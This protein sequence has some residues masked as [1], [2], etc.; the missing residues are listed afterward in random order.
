MTVDLSTCVPGQLCVNK[1]GEHF[2][3]VKR[4]D[5]PIHYPHLLLDQHSSQKTFTNDGIYD[6]R[7]PN[8]KYNIV[9]IIP[10]EST[11]SD[12]HPSLVWWESCP[13]ITDRTPTEADGNAVGWVMAKLKDS[14]DVATVFG[15][16][17][18]LGQPWIH[19]QDWQ[20]PVLSNKEKAL[21]LIAKRDA[22]SWKPTTDDW[23]VIRKGL[24]E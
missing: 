21:A 15:P 6:F 16:S 10:M 11:A 14:S 19:R 17:I 20:P 3:Y 18:T 1:D 12:K 9:H 7:Y 8:S 2:T 24:E 4:T 23:D 5:G 13:W 22:G